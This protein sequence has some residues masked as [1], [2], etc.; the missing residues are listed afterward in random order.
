[1][2]KIILFSAALL[3][4][5]GA[6]S[7]KG[8]QSGTARYSYSPHSGISQFGIKGGVNLAS[9]MNSDG[10]ETGTRTGIHLGFFNE[11][12]IAPKTDFRIE[13]LYSMQGGEDSSGAVDKIDYI[14]L[15]LIFK[16]YTGQ[17]RRFSI[18]AGPQLG[19]VVSAKGNSGG[20]DRDLSNYMNKFDLSLG[21]GIS[22]KINE[23]FDL[24]L[25]FMAGMT[26]M[27]DSSVLVRKNSV[28][29]IGAGYRFGY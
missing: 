28:V 25:R 14:T 27:F 13:L 4:A 21:F 26:K 17:G 11:S 5:T 8:A 7:Q 9:E 22:Y 18:D 20:S 19:L 1:M 29:Q 2:K 12:I 10:D 3:I 15:P 16:F 24:G 6:F 23:Q